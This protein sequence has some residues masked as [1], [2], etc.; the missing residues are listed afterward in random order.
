MLQSIGSQSVGLH[1]VT[2]QQLFT[3]VSHHQRSNLHPLLEVI[4]HFKELLKNQNLIAMKKLGISFIM[5]DFMATCQNLLFYVIF[6]IDWLPIE[7]LWISEF[8]LKH[9]FWRIVNI[10]MIVLSNKKRYNFIWL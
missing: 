8:N 6:I 2:E 3:E 9:S 10:L 1:C 7:R 5:I 4:G